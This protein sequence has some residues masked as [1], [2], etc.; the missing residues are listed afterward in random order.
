MVG[1]V[2]LD[3]RHAWSDRSDLGC[4]SE[5]LPDIAYA[6][7]CL[8]DDPEFCQWEPYGNYLKPK[9]SPPSTSDVSDFDRKGVPTNAL[10]K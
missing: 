7:T 5:Q 10:T 8:Y 1:R 4:T 6:A 3:L 2:G 9:I